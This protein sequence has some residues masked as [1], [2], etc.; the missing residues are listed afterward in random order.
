MPQMTTLIPGF[1][2]ILGGLFGGVIAS[3]F[4]KL[5]ILAKV[6]Q[7]HRSSL[8]FGGDDYVLVPDNK[9][10]FA[11]IVPSYECCFWACVA[12]V[13][14][15]CIS[16]EYE[17]PSSFVIILAISLL[18]VMSF[19]DSAVRI[20]PFE[21]TIVF[22]LL[23]AYYAINTYS[24]HSLVAV[25]TIAFLCFVFLK[26][27]NKITDFMKRDVPIGN[28]DVRIIPACVIMLGSGGCITMVFI[29][30]ILPTLWTFIKWL[31]GEKMSLK[32]KIP[33]IPY[34]TIGFIAGFF[35]C[36]PLDLALGGV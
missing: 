24:I 26:V 28:G 21:L 20:A 23:A 8:K 9:L 30:A 25:F 29:M 6:A 15:P 33:L 32:D 36:I 5:V 3:N 27:V 19:V 34:L 2:I 10:S 7:Y 4:A 18:I 13:A 16:L 11:E 35:P 22:Y 12:G 31:M 1:L 14:F 17:Y